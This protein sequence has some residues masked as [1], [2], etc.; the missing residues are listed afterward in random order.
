MLGKPS[1]NFRLNALLAYVDLPNHVEHFPGW[2]ALQQVS[3][4]PRLQC[5]PHIHITLEC[6]K[7]DDAGVGRLRPDGGRQVEA[8]EIRETK[9]HQGNVGSQG[10]K[11][12]NPFPAVRGGSSQRHVGLV[13]DDGA[14]TLPDQRMVVDTQDSD[15]TC[16]GLSRSFLPGTPIICCLSRD[17]SRNGDEHFCT[18][19]RPAPYTESRTDIFRP[20]SHPAETRGRIVLFSRGLGIDLAAVVTNEHAPAVADV[21]NFNLDLCRFGMT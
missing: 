15:T 16:V 1:G 14:D 11:G 2:R 10:A 13:V 9:V 7:H 18:T 20:L 8:A 17:V 3:T 12:F 4:S 6:R 21:L 19:T 5:P